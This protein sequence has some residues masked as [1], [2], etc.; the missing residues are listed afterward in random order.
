[1]MDGLHQQAACDVVLMCAV[2]L[3]VQT[4]GKTEEMARTDINQYHT[5]LPFLFIYL[6]SSCSSDWPPSQ[7]PFKLTLA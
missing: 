5:P 3:Q 1:M 6:L 4:A 2:L 7:T